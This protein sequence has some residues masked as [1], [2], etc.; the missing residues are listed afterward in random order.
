[1]RKNQH[2]SFVNNYNYFNNIMHILDQ[3]QHKLHRFDQGFSYDK[4][5]EAT[6]NYDHDKFLY[7]ALETGVI[8]KVYVVL[9]RETPILRKERAIINFSSS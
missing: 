4:L 3:V 8:G 5:L 7:S 2:V 9:S 1:M 6:I